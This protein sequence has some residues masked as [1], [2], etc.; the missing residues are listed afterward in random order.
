MIGVVILMFSY[1]KSC[2]KHKQDNARIATLLDYKHEVKEYTTKDGK[3]VSYNTNITVTP[4]DLKLVGDTLLNY[5]KSLELKIKNVYSS[6]IITER[7]RIDSVPY[8][9]YLTDCAFD[10]TIQILDSNYMIDLTLRNTG[11][12]FNSIEIP[13]RRGVTIAKHR[14]KW[15]KK[16]ETIVT[17]TNS[18]PYIQTDGISS[19]TFKQKKKI[20]ERPIIPLAAGGALG[21]WLG[22]KLAK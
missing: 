19:Y 15:W 12:L 4:E 22:I 7:V 13:N 17:V 8:P 16:K 18:N 2:S 1:V 9:V 6:T 21:I 10:T 11:I 14:E 5:I 20:W 3:K